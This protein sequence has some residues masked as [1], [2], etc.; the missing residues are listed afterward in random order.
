MLLLLCASYHGVT[1]F[2]ALWGTTERQL[3]CLRATS[4]AYL[5]AGDPVAKV[6]IHSVIPGHKQE[7]L[8]TADQS[9]R[10]HVLMKSSHYVCRTDAETEGSYLL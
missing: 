2:G 10:H 7:E 5:S 6:G 3:W 8:A 9:V 4:H 1:D